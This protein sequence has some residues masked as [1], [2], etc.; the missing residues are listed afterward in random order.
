MELTKAFSLTM[1]LLHL[2]GIV[3]IQV[4]HRSSVKV[5][6]ESI[7]FFGLIEALGP[8]RKTVFLKSFAAFLMIKKPF[9]KFTAGGM[10]GHS[11]K[12]KVVTFDVVD[13]FLNVERVLVNFPIITEAQWEIFSFFLLI[14]KSRFTYFELAIGQVNAV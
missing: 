7:E 6:R 3:Q 4:E 8:C 9:G 5:G 11:D 2:H 14:A 12:V 10:I 13:K 1:R